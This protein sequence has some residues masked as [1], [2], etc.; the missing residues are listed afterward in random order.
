M[1]ILL[2]SAY[3]P[4][5]G[6]IAIWT[7]QY[8]EWMKKNGHRVD[9][10]NL[11]VQGKRVQNYTHK[12]LF[13]EIFRAVKILGTCLFFLMFRRYDVVHFN[14]SCSKSG[15]LRDKLVSDMLYAFKIKTVVQCH[16]NL[17]VSLKNKR[18]RKIFA[19]MIKKERICLVLNQ[20]SKEIVKEYYNKEAKIV[21]NFLSEEFVAIMY[22][23]REYNDEMRK[24][25]FVGHLL[26]T[27]GCDTIIEVAKQMPD[28]E[29]R[30][31]GHISKEIEAMERTENVIFIG[32][33]ERKEV[34][35]EYRNADAFLFPTHTEGFPLAVAEAM[36]FGLPIIATKVGAIPDMAENDGA[37]YVEVGNEAEIKEALNT[38][39]NKEKRKKMSEFNKNK[40][41]N[42]YMIDSVINEL[43][44]IY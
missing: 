29:F 3:P 33:K 44:S 12:S 15:I 34:Y 19:D 26:R 24:V 23:H 37:E 36:A 42:N 38:L 1:K 5:A 14:T 28:L 18:T 31:V 39:R 25:L 2:I 30:L 20:D 4:P 41:F 6:G 13:A 35:E 11:S 27:K 40:V 22:E 32:E 9:L 16:C 7:E 43:C 8:M 10:V 17:P 21:P